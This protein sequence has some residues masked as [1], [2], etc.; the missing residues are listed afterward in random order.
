MDK[1]IQSSFGILFQFGE[2]LPRD[3]TDAKLQTD[4]DRMTFILQSTSDELIYNM[5]ENNDKKLTALFNLY[6]YLAHALL[7]FQPW[8]FGSVSLRMMEIT[9]KTGLCT[10][11]PLAFAHFGSLAVTIGYVTVGCRLGEWLLIFVRYGIKYDDA[12]FFMQLK[13]LQERLHSN[14]WRGKDHRS[15]NQ[16]SLVLSTM[17]YYGQRNPFNQLWIHTCK[18]IRPVNCQGISYTV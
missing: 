4:I 9:M 13:M 5:Q 6:V 11:S 18:D 1:S 16:K 3:M 14:C 8:L 17:E 2:E 12:N 10:M 15:T 7:Y